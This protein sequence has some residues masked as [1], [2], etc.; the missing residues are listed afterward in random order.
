MS[1]VFTTNWGNLPPPKSTKVSHIISSIP[2][3]YMAWM[4]NSEWPI[5]MPFTDHM[6]DTSPRKITGKPDFASSILNFGSHANCYNTAQGPTEAQ[7]V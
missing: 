7:D 3:R 2:Y 4:D 5:Y 1:N 6:A